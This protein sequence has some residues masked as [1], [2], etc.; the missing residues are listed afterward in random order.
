MPCSV[1]ERQ[2][3]VSI[4]DDD[5]AVRRALTRMLRSAGFTICD[6]PSAEAF[7]EQQALASIDCVILDL[8]MPGISGLEL[9]RHLRKMA[10]PFPV[11]VMSGLNEPQARAECLGEGAT[12]FFPKPVDNDKLTDTLTAL[13]ERALKGSARK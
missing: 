8:Q 9:L 10:A 4:V 6:Y 1:N 3:T 12:A 13:R 5:A 7:L 2:F 11:L